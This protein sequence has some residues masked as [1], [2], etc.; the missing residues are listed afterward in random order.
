MAGPDMMTSTQGDGTLTDLINFLKTTYSV[1]D[2]VLGTLGSPTS[3]TQST[4]PYTIRSKSY[5]EAGIARQDIATNILST[6]SSLYCGMVLMALQAQNMVASGVKV[7]DILSTV[8][9]EARTPFANLAEDLSE[10]TA[11]LEAL[12]HDPYTGKRKSSSRNPY[13]GSSSSSTTSSQNSDS[14]R[15]QRE[16][17]QRR[18]DEREDARRAEDKAQRD[19]DQ[20]R[21]EEREDSREAERR[22]REDAEKAAVTVDNKLSAK[23]ITVAGPDVLPQGSLIDVTLVG[24]D[25]NG[26]QIPQHVVMAVHM[27]PFIVQ[28]NA[29]ELILGNA[30]PGSFRQRLTQYHAGEISSIKDLIFQTNRIA[31]ITKALTDDKSGGFE[32]YLK[33]AGKKDKSHIRNIFSKLWSSKTMSSNIANSVLVVSEDTVS[34]VKGEYK[35][36]LHS[37]GDR[38]RF[39]KNSYV[40]MIWV[41]D[42]AYERVTL[43]LNGV[44]DVGDYSYAQLKPKSKNDTANLVQ[45]MAAMSQNRAPRF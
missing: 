19:A 29:A 8:A 38:A 12:D 22:Q 9:T 30:A 31:K 7:G 42:E 20:K 26:A 2:R 37:G 16:R 3:L 32:A 28:S 18:R 41:V 15:D 5:V 34:A 43:Y 44:E 11:G 25:K 40:M 27:V 21:R 45:V 39:F 17:D 23:D 14:Q 1:T 35:F 24:T 13:T 6:S 4:K 36:D 33:E 10:M